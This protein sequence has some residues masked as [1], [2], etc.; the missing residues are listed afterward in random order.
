M[1][2]IF[3]STGYRLP[4]EDRATNALMAVLR[5]CKP[6]VLEGFL[7]LAW[8]RKVCVADPHEVEFELQVAFD[9]SRPDASIAGPS[10]LVVIETKRFDNLEEHQFRRHLR[11]LVHSD[12]PTL[13]LALTGGGASEDLVRAIARDD[14][15]SSLEV[16]HLSWSEVLRFSRRMQERYSADSVSGFLLQQLC[17]YLEALGYNYFSGVPMKDLVDYGKAM[18][19]VVRHEKSTLPQ[20][21]S[22]LRVLA[23]HLLVTDEL[24]DLEWQVDD[25]GRI[26][27]ETE[28]GWVSFPFLNANL[29]T[30]GQ[31]FRFRV[32]PFLKLPD[33]AG[34]KYYLT[35]ADEGETF[36][37]ATRWFL[38]NRREVKAAIP[39]IA[40]LGYLDKKKSLFHV[41]R[42]VFPE[43]MSALLMGD[44]ASLRAHASEMSEFFRQMRK[45]VDRAL[46]HV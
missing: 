3:K 5:H 35:C 9:G 29:P 30:V 26:D 42:E 31:A 22:F 16:G 36:G 18:I 39:N 25:F 14:L 4:E 44:E 8:R 23:G 40:H 10:F 41:S 7:E 12:R 43:D 27:V 20:I 21:R 37:R 33:G 6:A 38:D 32:L 2:N 24:K 28:S 11:N 15:G 45:L 13:L 34:L 46:E 17:D 19:S 1:L